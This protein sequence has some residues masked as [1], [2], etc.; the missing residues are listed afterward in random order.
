MP[1]DDIEFPHQREGE[2]QHGPDVHVLSVVLLVTH[3]KQTDI[4]IFVSHTH[5]QMHVD[6]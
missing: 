6:V 5:R 1:V 2:L 3:K 4:H